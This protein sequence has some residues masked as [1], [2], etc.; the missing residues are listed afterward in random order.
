MERLGKKSF[1]SQ[2]PI[3]HNEDQSR[4]SPTGVAIPSDFKISQLIH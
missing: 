1:S 3:Q 4:K 2:K